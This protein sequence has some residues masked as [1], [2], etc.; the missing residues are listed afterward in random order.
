MFSVWSNQKFVVVK[1]LNLCNSAFGLV[2]VKLPAIFYAAF[3]LM[4][5][6]TGAE[7]RSA[8]GRADAVY[9]FKFKLTGGE[10][11]AV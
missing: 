4:G 6:Y 5:Q 10:W 11:K 7:L 9:V 8:E 3:T 1:F 2:N